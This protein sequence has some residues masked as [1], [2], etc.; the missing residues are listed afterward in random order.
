MSNTA[1]ATAPYGY[2]SNC[3]NG[4]TGYTWHVELE[5][6]KRKRKSACS[7][8]T[9]YALAILALF[10]ACATLCFQI[11]S[12]V[13]A[14]RITQSQRMA[15][16]EALASVSKAGLQASRG[17][18]VW[19]AI[20]YQWNMTGAI[21]QWN[22]Y[23]QGAPAAATSNPAIVTTAPTVPPGLYA[24][25]FLMSLL[26][27]CDTGG[28]YSSPCNSSTAIQMCPQ[29]GM[30]MSCVDSGLGQSMV[31]PNFC[32]KSQSPPSGFSTCPTPVPDQANLLF[33]YRKLSFDAVSNAHPTAILSSAAI[34][35]NGGS[36]VTAPLLV[37]FSDQNNCSLVINVVDLCN[38]RYP[39]PRDVVVTHMSV[40]FY[41]AVPAPVV[42]SY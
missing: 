5:D 29:I 23:S 11:C 25:D 32:G 4:P 36:S 30:Y 18:I 6:P 42:I 19:Q 28:A 1:S 8:R 10:L 2:S 27:S 34:S 17:Y 15:V 9:A 31:Q 24:V 7:K 20:G 33:A 35:S 38:A 22:S 13:R 16:G 14:Y 3:G 21:N 39:Y 12:A 40:N 37:D 26:Y 41:N